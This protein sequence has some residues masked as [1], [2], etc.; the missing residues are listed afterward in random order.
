MQ[1]ADLALPCRDTFWNVP[2]WAQVALY[3]GSV[4]A[5][6]VFAHGMWRRVA[7]WRQGGPEARLD[8]IPERC[9]LLLKHGLGQARTLT[10][11][12]PGIMHALMFWG[13]CVLFLGTVLATID[14]DLLWLP[15]GVK[16]LTGRFYLAYEL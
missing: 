12:Y 16:I 8:R 7:L 10:Q 9:L 4:V 15:L 3:V 13:F 6:A 2:G 14:Y 5:V 1:C 11:R